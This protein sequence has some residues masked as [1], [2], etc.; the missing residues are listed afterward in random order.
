MGGNGLVCLVGFDLVISFH[1][2]SFHGYYI[3]IKIR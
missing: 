2:F 3:I 1:F